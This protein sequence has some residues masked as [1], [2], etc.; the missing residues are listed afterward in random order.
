MTDSCHEEGFLSRPE[1][2]RAGIAAMISWFPRRTFFT[3]KSIPIVDTYRVM[4][5][6]SQYRLMR[7]D[8]PTPSE[9][10]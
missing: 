9:N 10:L 2:S 4:N 6:S 1:W 7:Q 5:L 8:F 3:P